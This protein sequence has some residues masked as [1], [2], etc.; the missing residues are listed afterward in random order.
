[1]KFLPVP[2]ASDTSSNRAFPLKEDKACKIPWRTTTWKTPR[3]AVSGQIAGS[4][5]TLDLG[6]GKCWIWEDA[7]YHPGIFSLFKAV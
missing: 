6:G 3:M 7:V 5:C 1:M 2:W 4:G